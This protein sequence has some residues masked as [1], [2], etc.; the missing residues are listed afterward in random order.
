MREAIAR[1]AAHLHADAPGFTR[2]NLF[3]AVRRML[4]ADVAEITFDVELRRWLSRDSIPGLLPAPIPWTSRRLSRE[5]DAYFPA[6]I[7]LVDR[8]PILDLFV[9]SGVI[10]KARLAVVC[11]DGSPP[12]VVAWL[13]R[14][15]RAGRRAPIVYLHDAATVVYPFMLEPLATRVRYPGQEPILYRDLGVPPRGATS[16]LFDEPAY[17]DPEPILELEAVA[18]TTLVRYASRAAL[19]LIPGDPNMLPLTREGERQRLLHGGERA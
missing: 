13:Q 16:A 18:P 15:F 1:C 4:G 6:A 12:S 14:G 19:A 7:V 2:R 8:Q 9:A 3:Y 10:P 5:W 11:I 17:D